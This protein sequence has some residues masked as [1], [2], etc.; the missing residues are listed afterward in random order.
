M[1][2]CSFR[3]PFSGNTNDILSKAK[4]AIQSQDGIFSGDESAGNFNVSV[5]GNVIKG[6]YSVMDQDLN[7]V[8][9]S[10]PFFIP[11]STIE[12]FLKNKIGG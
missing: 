9:E 1:G 5:L 12:S 7:I 2:A 6:S 10:K 11:C 4:T 8:I 3:I